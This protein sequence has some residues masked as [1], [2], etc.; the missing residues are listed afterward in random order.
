MSNQD[1]L[2]GN[3]KSI[4]GAVKEK[5][6]QISSDDLTKVEGNYDQF[7]GLLQRKAGQTREQV[8]SFLSEVYDEAGSTY[9][10]VAKQAGHMLE[11]AGDYMHE[12]YDQVTET[13]E[14]GYENA[15]EVVT[16]RPI[17][18]IAVV[19]GVALLGGLLVGLSLG[20]NRR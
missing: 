12:G 4:V 19:A 15:R 11:N 16:R 10:R 20:S 18:S 17:E 7:V 5:W 13:L 8:E 14:R 9:N 1:V 3:W 2:K 6:G